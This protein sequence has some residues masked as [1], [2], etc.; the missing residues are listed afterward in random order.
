MRRDKRKNDEIRKLEIEVGFLKNHFNSVMLSQGNTKLLCVATIEEKIPDFLEGQEKGWITAEY[1]ML[2]YSSSQGRIPRDVRSGRWVEIQRFIG[3]SLRAAFNLNLIYPFTIKVDCDVLQADGG[4]R[5]SAVNA[6]FVSVVLLLNELLKKGIIKRSPLKYFIGAVSVGK[7][8]GESLLDLD[9]SED[10]IAEVDL[11]IVSTD[12]RKII[13]I[14]GTGENSIFT[15]NELSSFI[16][17]AFK[18]IDEII[19]IEKNLLQ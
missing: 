6:G 11:N 12:K 9:Y 1:G 8:E 16:S 10:S 15:A 4:T 14:Q 3:R 5:T 2:P 13:E 19:R 17:L 7:V 18:G